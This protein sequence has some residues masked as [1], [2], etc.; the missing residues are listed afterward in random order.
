[1]IPVALLG[2]FAGMLAIGFT[3]NQLTLFAMVLAI[4]IVV[5]DAIV[6][7]ENV[8]RIMTEEHLEP[9]AA[10]QKGNDTNH[11]SGDMHISIVLT[12][13]IYPFCDATG[14]RWSDLQT[15]CTDNCDVNGFFSIPGAHLH[16]RTMREFP[17]I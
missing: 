5:D 9:K 10:T 8:E 6:V 16:A 17:E 7:I 15:I 2:T 1:M 3:I 12:A 11:R 14:G 13:S 4:G